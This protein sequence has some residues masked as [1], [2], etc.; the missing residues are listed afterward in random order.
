LTSSKESF[1]VGNI[2]DL[3]VTKKNKSGANNKK[4]KEEI[5]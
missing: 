4:I 2:R 3:L 1:F 5:Q